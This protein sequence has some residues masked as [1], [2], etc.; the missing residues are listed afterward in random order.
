M[1]LNFELTDTFA[2]EANYSWVRRGQ[3]TLPGYDAPTERGIVKAA[4]AWAGWTGIYCNKFNHSD[5]VIELRPR[6][7][8]QVLFITF[9]D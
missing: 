9:E 3:K 8:A 5:G 7:I 4:K 2:G 1:K 6:H